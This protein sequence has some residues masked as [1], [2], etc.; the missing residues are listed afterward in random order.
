MAGRWHCFAC[1]SG[2]DAVALVQAYA[3]VGFRDAV[4]LIEAGG[5]LP[6]G[7]DPHLHLR[8]A[9]RTAGGELSWE[10]TAGSDREP[11]DLGR[12]P[13]ARLYEAM[14]MAWWYYSQQGVARLARRH[15]AER[16]IDL[17]ALEVREGRSLAGHTPRSRTGLVEYL[18][19]LRFNDDEA[20]DAGLVSRHPDGAVEDF[21]THR[22]VLPVR[23]A[24]DWVVGLIGRD[25]SGGLRAKYLNTPK[26]GIY[27]KG[28]RLYR[29]SRVTTSAT[30]AVVVEGAI[31]A[32]AIDA[33]AV[34]ARLEI[35]AVSPSGTAF[36]AEHRAQVTAWFSSPPILCGDG[37]GAGRAATYR[38]VTEMTLEGRE[39]FVLTLPDTFDPADWLKAHGLSG[40]RNF[41]AGDNSSATID[42]ICPLHSGRYLAAQVA[43]QLPLVASLE[44]V[45]RAGGH[46]AS[47][48]ERDRF[49]REAVVGFAEAG[50]GP[51]GWLERRL[52]SARTVSSSTAQPMHS[53]QY[54][55]D[56][57]AL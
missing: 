22:L 31:D 56:G 42:A 41:V 13:P 21:F 45:A 20:V 50:F 35:A 28:R 33:G 3:Q 9:T 11:P 48:P 25:V 34:Q 39:S 19:R 40:L 37:D 30:S 51:D 26:T 52:A 43:R 53:S 4:G 12:T 23:D 27:D 1:Q 14:G 36:T 7:D 46:F 17:G 49:L 8:P 29:P 24:H 10:A 57:I 18:R 38:W 2:G 32:L 44:A 6:R 5:R 54:R 47:T 16:S 55:Q 15:L